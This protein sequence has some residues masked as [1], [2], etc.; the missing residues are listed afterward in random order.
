M[1]LVRKHYDALKL[2]EQTDQPVVGGKLLSY[3]HSVAGGRSDCQFEQL[4][5]KAVD[6][7]FLFDMAA[8]DEANT[9]TCCVAI[10]AWGGMRRDHA[11]TVLG[12]ANKWLPIADA[13]RKQSIGRCD[14]Y[15]QFMQARQSK[16]L[17][18]MGP[19][20]FTKLI[21]FLGRNSNSRGYIM[22]QWTALSA[23][24][25]T[26]R[27]MVDMQ[28]LKGAARVSDNNSSDVYNEFCIFIEILAQELNESPD[29]AEIRI[30]SIG[31]RGEKKGKWRTYLKKYT[32][33]MLVQ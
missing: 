30:F 10:F 7:E 33:E 13:I 14:A 9:L 11:R 4:P 12:T 31:G 25:L 27:K 19:A 23:N 1:E 6:R 32:Q 18:G 22:D 3:A 21:Y 24:L 2:M 16:N 29:Q 5:D 15:S 28:I 8:S 26:G 20:F 17:P